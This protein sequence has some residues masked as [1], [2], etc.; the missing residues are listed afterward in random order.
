MNAPLRKSFGPPLNDRETRRGF[1]KPREDRL[2]LPSYLS[3]F[4]SAHAAHDPRA[5]HHRYKSSKDGHVASAEARQWFAADIV[6][7][8]CVMKH[9]VS[10]AKRLKVS[11]PIGSNRAGVWRCLRHICHSHKFGAMHPICA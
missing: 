9:G 7:L 5:A 3:H 1:A 6:A 10:T 8:R 11:S 2:V 4:V